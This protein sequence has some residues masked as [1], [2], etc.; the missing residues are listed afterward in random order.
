MNERLKQIMADHGLHKYITED[1]Q[2]RMEKLAELVAE[3][4]AQICGSQV[5][6][7][8]IRSAFGLKVES[9]VKY[10]SPEA[11]NSINSQYT[12]QIN[13]PPMEEVK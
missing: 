10:P 6:K 7:K 5:D 8:N 3:E 1:C 2:H 11:D 12:R 9:N 13:L 4:C